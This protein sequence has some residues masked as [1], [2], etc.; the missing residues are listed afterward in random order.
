MTSLLQKVWYEKYRPRTIQECILPTALKA[1]FQ[2]YVDDKFI[3]PVVFTGPPG[4]GKTS[5]A[6]ALCDEIECDTYLVNGSLNADIGTLRHDIQS[7]AA[8]VSMTGGRKMVRI[9]EADG[10]S[11]G[12][13]KALRN[14]SEEYSRN[15]GF[16]MT[17]NYPKKL[18][19][20][21]WS[22]FSEIQFT[23]PA[24]ERQSLAAQFYKR[25][26]YVLDQEGV[27]YEKQ[28]VAALIKQRFPD[29]RKVLTELQAYSNKTSGHIDVGI[30]AQSS[31]EAWKELYAALK[32]KNFSEMRT[33]VAIHPETESH[34]LFRKLYDD[35]SP[36]LTNESIPL[37]VL[38]LAEY[39]HKAALVADQEINNVA[40]LTQIMAD[41]AWK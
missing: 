2:G 3:P 22:R 34:V 27:T 38:I 40:C 35:L 1:R 24:E 19:E 33:W 10:L 6:A 21:I 37:M 20:A 7:F 28:A 4:L 23:I 26:L 30:L 16:V 17:A 5:V 41:V 29:F 39:Q 8:T 36:K 12:V 11:D 18:S 32:T 14:F 31:E 15:C 13:Q 9:E 25:V